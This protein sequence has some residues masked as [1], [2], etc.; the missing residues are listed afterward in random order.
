MSDEHEFHDAE[1]SEAQLQLLRDKAR[2][3]P[4]DIA[5]KPVVWTNIRERIESSRVREFPNAALLQPSSAD[6]TSNVQ[7]VTD[8]IPG[9]SRTRSLRV[10]RNVMLAAA[11]LFIV[12]TSVVVLR[13]RDEPSDEPSPVALVPSGDSM[14]TPAPVVNAPVPVAAAQSPTETTVAVAPRRLSPPVAAVLAQFN[15]AALDLTKDLDARRPRLQADALA[16]I[17]SCLHT[18]D[19]AIQES[20]AAL[21]DAP[22]NPTIVELLQLTYKQKLDL[23]RRAADL[24][25]GSL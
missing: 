22:D 5:P 19:Q 21:V 16:V 20:R 9:G 17:D 24:P 25:T 10:T 14:A 3:L 4:S 7:P 15:A 23:L 11:S 1:F 12:V 6:S 2:A 18:I 8:A 13:E